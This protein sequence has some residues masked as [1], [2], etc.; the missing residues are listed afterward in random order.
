MGAAGGD[1]VKLSLDI[2][3]N[4]YYI[5]KRETNQRKTLRETVACN[6]INSES[7]RVEAG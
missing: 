2:P 3:Q 1:F 5:E 4:V 6:K 7:G